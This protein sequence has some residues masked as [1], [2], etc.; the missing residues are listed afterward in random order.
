MS[1]APRGLM[2]SAITLSSGVSKVRRGEKISEGT[3]VPKS[4][5]EACFKRRVGDTNTEQTH[6]GELKSENSDGPSAPM[7]LIQFSVN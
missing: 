6:G 2:N 1:A 4:T 3:G 7:A 5:A